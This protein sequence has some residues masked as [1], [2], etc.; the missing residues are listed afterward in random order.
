[1]SQKCEVCLGQHLTKDHKK[2]TGS[3][4]EYRTLKVQAAKNGWIV[5]Q[6][7]RVTEVYIR[8]ESLVHRL[9]DEL[10]NNG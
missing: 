8:W 9:R 2:A 3:E 4:P 6:A 5:T 7:G 10:T 1:M